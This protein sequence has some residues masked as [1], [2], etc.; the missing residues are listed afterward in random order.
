MDCEGNMTE[1]TLRKLNDILENALRWLEAQ[2]DYLEFQNED[3]E[4]WAEEYALTMLEAEF[5]WLF[6]EEWA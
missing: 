5:D 4:W 2:A 3:R 6:K 1:E